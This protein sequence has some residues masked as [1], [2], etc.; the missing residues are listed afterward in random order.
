MS[1]SWE[2]QRALYRQLTADANLT[3]LTGGPRIFD[4]PPQQ[5]DYPYLTLGA[6]LVRD[7]STATEAGEE[8][9]LT[10]HVWSRAPGSRQA[11]QIL[12]AVRQ[13]LHDEALPL[14]G[15]ALINLRHEFSDVRFDTQRDLQHGITRYRAVTEPLS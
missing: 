15:H 4:K 5:L 12:A 7:W 6:S 9:I 14:T 1:S 8:H 3:A 2:L 13:S 10:I 11:Q